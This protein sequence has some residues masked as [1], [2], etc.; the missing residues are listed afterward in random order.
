MKQ[1]RSHTKFVAVR[2]AAFGAMVFRDMCSGDPLTAPSDT[3]LLPFLLR[4]K[5]QNRLWVL[6]PGQNLVASLMWLLVRDRRGH[7]T[8][9]RD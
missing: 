6:V 9:G 2:R 1:T 7:Q 3:Q 4:R 8:K 5:G